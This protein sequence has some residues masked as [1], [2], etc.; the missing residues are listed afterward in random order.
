[1]PSHSA[2]E[3]YMQ[4]FLE[5]NAQNAV[6]GYYSGIGFSSVMC[7][8]FLF[9]TRQKKRAIILKDSYS[10]ISVWMLNISGFNLVVQIIFN[11]Y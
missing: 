7:F 3:G 5:T 10:R 8:Y 11:G 2:Y 1:M 4:S 6:N 9:K